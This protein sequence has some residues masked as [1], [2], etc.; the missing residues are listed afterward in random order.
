MDHRVP[1][2]G[3]TFVQGQELLHVGGQ[4]GVPSDQGFVLRA[5]GGVPAPVGP[6][7]RAAQQG[8]GQRVDQGGWGVPGDE[9]T[10]LAL[11]HP[12]PVGRQVG[13][14]RQAACSHGL[15]QADRGAVRLGHAHEQ[16]A[17]A[18]GPG[19]IRGGQQAREFHAVGHPQGLRQSA[20]RG[21]LL[22]RSRHLQQPTRQQRRGL[23]E[24]AQDGIDAVQRLVQPARQDTALTHHGPEISLGGRRIDAQRNPL[25]PGRRA[26]S[27]DD[28]RGLQQHPGIGRPG[29]RTAQRG[30]HQGTLPPAAVRQAQHVRSPEG[31]HHRHARGPRSAHCMPGRGIGLVHVHHRGLTTLDQRAQALR[32]AHVRQPQA[33]EDLFAQTF[34][35]EQRC[36]AIRHQHHVAPRLAQA[37]DE[38]PHMHRVRADDEHGTRAR[39]CVLAKGHRFWQVER[40]RRRGPR[41]FRTGLDGPASFRR[42]APRG[43]PRRD[44][45]GPAAPRC[46]PPAPGRSHTA[47]ASLPRHR[48]RAR[49]HPSAGR[50]RWAA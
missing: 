9:Q 43:S 7:V 27:G 13:Q 2:R 26:G 18:V 21:G 29:G 24:G 30:A 36:R 31:E 19:Q 45:P 23:G 1:R 6:P 48:A 17:A 14:H 8:P 5:S 38:A 35:G 46:R 20:Q 12:L 47:P 4:G 49:P 34:V 10:V 40:S 11:A 50:R 22:S 42:A 16:R 3:H 32:R 25:L 15:E 33:H 44:R 39:E 37:R 28:L 41:G